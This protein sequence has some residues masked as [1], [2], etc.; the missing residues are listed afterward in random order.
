MGWGGVMGWGWGGSGVCC[1]D[2]VAIVQGLF[3]GCG[4]EGFGV[5]WLEGDRGDGVWGGDGAGVR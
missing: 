4:G 3:V 1:G 5:G 2:G